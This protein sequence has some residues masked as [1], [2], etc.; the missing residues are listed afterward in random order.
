[1]RIAHLVVGVVGIVAF[2]ATG[3]YMDLYHA[4]LVGMPDVQ[5]ML[6]RSTH[7]YLLLASITNAALGLHLTPSMSGWRRVVAG[8]GSTLLLLAPLLI[9][10]GFS[11]EPWLSNLDRPYSRPA[12]FGSL[13][14]IV[15]H[16]VAVPWR[17][18]GG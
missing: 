17:R 9:L 4:H 12:L 14:G 15:L 8:V 10:I 6:F 1:L 2:I 18:R 7:I 5:R 3:Q 11:T 16:L 13:A